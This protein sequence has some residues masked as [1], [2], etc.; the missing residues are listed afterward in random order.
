MFLEISTVSRKLHTYIFCLSFLN[1]ITK[2][3]M[4]HF[5]ILQSNWTKSQRCFSITPTDNIYMRENFAFI[6]SEKKQQPV[7]YKVVNYIINYS[8]RTH[9][10]HVSVK[11]SHLKKKIKQLLV[12][13]YR[14][15]KS[16]LSKLSSET[17]QQLWKLGLYYS[18][19]EK[20]KISF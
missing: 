14:I 18:F 15:K 9:S 2:G 5:N 4:T 20:I 16:C 19:S 10:C 17:W 11:A 7:N 3:Q 13:S 1:T 8:T 12:N 6:I